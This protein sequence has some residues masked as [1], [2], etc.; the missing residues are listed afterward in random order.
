[1]DIDVLKGMHFDSLIVKYKVGRN[2]KF[3]LN[4]FLYFILRKADLG[5]QVTDIELQWLAENSLFN[6]IDFN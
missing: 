5:I 2:R 3:S 1:M 6:C 4:S